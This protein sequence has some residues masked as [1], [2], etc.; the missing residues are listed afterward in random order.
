MSLDVREQHFCFIE[1][2][3]KDVV[4]FVNYCRLH[5]TNMCLNLHHNGTAFNDPK[6]EGF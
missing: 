6:K 3:C 4:L 2:R 5:F 1:I